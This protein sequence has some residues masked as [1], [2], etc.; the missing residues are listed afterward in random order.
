MLP[1]G[2]PYLRDTDRFDYWAQFLVE[3]GYAVLKPNFRGSAGY[4]DA[5]L[6]AGFEEWGGAMQNDLIDGVDWMVEQGLA[7]PE[8]V[9]IVGGSYGGYAALVAAFSTPERFRCAAAFAGVTNLDRLVERWRAFELGELAAAHVQT[10]AERAAASPLE[11]VER[12][13][14]PLLIVH[15]DL[16]RSVMIEQSRDLV[17]ALEAADKP[18]RYIEQPGGDHHLSLQSHRREFLSSLEAFL[19]E[20]LAAEAP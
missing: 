1:H 15:G 10:G 3:R 12:I 9:C 20:H 4:G 13:E 16:D 14:L 7:D 5:F 17:A 2:G 8:R 6:E 18:V 11:Q 19:G